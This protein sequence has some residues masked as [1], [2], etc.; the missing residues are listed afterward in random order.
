MLPTWLRVSASPERRHSERRTA[1]AEAFRD[2]G[3]G[4]PVSSKAGST[5]A[6]KAIDH[7]RSTGHHPASVH[8]SV[9]YLRRAVDGPLVTPPCDS[10]VCLEPLQDQ[11]S[12][13]GLENQQWECTM[14]KRVQPPAIHTQSIPG[15]QPLWMT[16]GAE[17]FTRE[18][19]FAVPEHGRQ[20]KVQGGGRGRS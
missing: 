3:C 10:K 12:S 11:V 15:L 13:A 5:R 6:T 18:Q 19:I 4:L 20:F 17:D 14:V 9:L 8:L 7:E 2:Q 1:L 16:L